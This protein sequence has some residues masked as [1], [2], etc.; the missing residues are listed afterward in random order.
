MFSSTSLDPGNEIYDELE[1][2]KKEI[3]FLRYF[4]NAA[5]DAFGPAES[6]IYYMI[7]Q[8]YEGEVPKEYKNEEF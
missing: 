4:Y 6:D 1:E 2:L 5:G 3:A 7:I 8:D